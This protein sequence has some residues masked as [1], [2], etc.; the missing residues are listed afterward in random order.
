M[1]SLN[2]IQNK[3]EL[4]YRNQLSHRTEPDH[5]CDGYEFCDRPTG[6]TSR[7]VPVLTLSPMSGCSGDAGKNRVLVLQS[8]SIIFRIEYTNITF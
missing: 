7:R 1:S 3:T 2:Y 6:I 8:G 5:P 4:L